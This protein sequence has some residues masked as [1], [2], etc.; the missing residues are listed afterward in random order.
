MKIS[1]LKNTIQLK[2]NKIKELEQRIDNLVNSA[3]NKPK[4]VYYN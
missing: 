3:N 2:D 4:L 1:N